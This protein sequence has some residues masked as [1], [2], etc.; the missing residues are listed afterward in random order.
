MA[1]AK[2]TEVEKLYVAMGQIR[3]AQ[4]TIERLRRTEGL[5]QVVQNLLEHSETWIHNTCGAL[6]EH[7]DGRPSTFKVCPAPTDA[8]PLFPAVNG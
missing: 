6:Q 5:P 7:I 4:H 8:P 3:S 1:H 2:L